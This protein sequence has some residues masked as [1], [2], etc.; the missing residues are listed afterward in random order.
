MPTSGLGTRLKAANRFM[1]LALRISLAEADIL[2]L[3]IAID[4]TSGPTGRAEGPHDRSYT[5]D[6]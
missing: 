4:K 6:S 1:L 3:V 5:A 2:R